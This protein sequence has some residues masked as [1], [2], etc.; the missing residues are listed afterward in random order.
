MKYFAYGSNCNPEVLARKDVR[1]HARTRATLSGYRLRFNK[2]ALRER[3]PEDVGFANIEVASG[4]AVE[5]V[6]YD[7]EPEDRDRL[8][9][10]E[11]YPDH[12]ERIDVVVETDAG[13]VACFAY[14]ACA[15]KTAEG[16][17][18][19]RN[20][21][22]HILEASDFLSHAYF[23]AVESFQTYTGPCI[24]CQQTQEVIFLREGER[25]YML[26]Q[27]CREARL[28]WGSTRGRKLSVRE[29]AAVMQLVRERGG[30]PSIQAL[31][32]EAIALRIIDP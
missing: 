18:P 15:D 16:L 10:S 9:E 12:Y 4:A 23:E 19:S 20:Y 32:D 24:S 28:R 17:R 31:I 1:F 27:P 7:L 11:R 14:R 5:G 8:D 25:I 13:E 26:C 29:T 21:V 22:N 6:L 2:K 3:L 30:F